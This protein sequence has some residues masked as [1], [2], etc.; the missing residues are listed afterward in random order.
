MVRE[1]L[2]RLQKLNHG[3][4]FHCLPRQT[5]PTTAK[6]MCL[7]TWVA[8]GVWDGYHHVE[9]DAVEQK[10]NTEECLM[11]FHIAWSCLSSLVVI[12][13]LVWFLILFFCPC[14]CLFVGCEAREENGWRQTCGR[15][16][17]VF[18]KGAVGHEI[19]SNTNEPVWPHSQ[20]A[21]IHT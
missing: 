10:Y 20:T 18:E 21:Y 12:G 11:Q 17:G 2:K 3:A 15:L 14:P 19:I 9:L 7:V 13:F 5:D 4:K 8:T 1:R 16:L 6:N